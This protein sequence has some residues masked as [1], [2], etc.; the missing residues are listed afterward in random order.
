MPATDKTQPRQ[1]LTSGTYRH[2]DNNNNNNNNMMQKEEEE[3]E[4][5]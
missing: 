2:L 1:F 4:K 3:K 5:R